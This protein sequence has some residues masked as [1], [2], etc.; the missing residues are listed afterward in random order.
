MT[1][2]DN[3]KPKWKYKIRNNRPLT[4]GSWSRSLKDGRNGEAGYVYIVQ[5]A[6]AQYKIGMTGDI[7]RRL[8]N[9]RTSNLSLRLV[10]SYRMPDMKFAEKRLHRI[11]ES[12][13]IER[14]VY[15]LSK[16]DIYAAERIL[17]KMQKRTPQQQLER[18]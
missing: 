9:L 11:F 16:R 10:L 15:N 13:H 5:L 3:K 6:E 17:A 12:R 8:S 7:N 18:E 14:E 4:K 1:K 2:A